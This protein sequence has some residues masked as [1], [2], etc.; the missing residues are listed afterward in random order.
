MNFEKRKTPMLLKL[1]PLGYPT[2]MVQSSHKL[3]MHT[4]Y[5][6]LLEHDKRSIL[7]SKSCIFF[8]SIHYKPFLTSADPSDASA[9]QRGSLTQL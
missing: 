8:L 9:E 3:Y 4:H 2:V 7:A 1:T 6:Y 5:R